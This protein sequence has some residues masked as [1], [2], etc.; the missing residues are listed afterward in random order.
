MVAI[1]E[2]LTPGHFAT[3]L[4]LSVSPDFTLRIRIV[5][6]SISIV[7]LP[8]APRIARAHVDP[9]VSPAKPSPLAWRTR[10][11]AAL[12]SLSVNFATSGDSEV[13]VTS[14]WGI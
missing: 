6:G 9:T 12:A 2:D 1:S 3:R 10:P 5:P 11:Q 14:K 4:N 8:S 13:M 7:H